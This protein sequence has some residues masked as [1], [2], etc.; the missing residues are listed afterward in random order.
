MAL[1]NWF[2][3]N[4][5]GV[6]PK[7]LMV[8]YTGHTGG[9]NLNLDGEP[10]W[11]TATDGTEARFVIESTDVASLWQL[12]AGTHVDD[13]INGWKR[14]LDYEAT[15]N[16]KVWHKTAV[17]G[18]GGG[19][20]GE[21]ILVTMQEAVPAFVMVTSTGFRADSTNQAHRG[22]VVGMTTAAVG[23]GE[24]ATLSDDDEVT[25]VGWSWSPGQNVFLNGNIVSA[26]PPSTGFSQK[27]GMARN[28]N[29]LVLQIGPAIQL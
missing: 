9:G 18:A 21:F 1:Y 28:A 26:S 3:T 12:E 24:V 19:A 8:V 17:F 11:P 14:P 27:V 5:F 10:T 23:I 29:I 13:P 15:Q 22:K 4:P 25:N 7:S 20:G 16:A 2:L 6:G